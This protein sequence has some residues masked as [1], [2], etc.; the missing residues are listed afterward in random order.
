MLT[1]APEGS[2]AISTTPETGPP[3]PP[4]GLTVAGMEAVSV[5]TGGATGVG[6]LTGSA[7]GLGLDSS[8]EAAGAGPPADGAGGT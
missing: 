1:V 8:T 3:L 5:D 2:D 4:L 7:S 6:G